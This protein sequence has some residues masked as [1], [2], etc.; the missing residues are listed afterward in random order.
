[1]TVMT[2][3]L[4]EEPQ[5]QK[6][7]EFINTID[8]QLTKMNWLIQTLLTLSKI[9]AGTVP[10]V[11]EPFAVSELIACSVRPFLIPLELKN[12]SLRLPDAAFTLTGDKNWTV[13]AL[14]NII[15]NCMEHTP[16]GGEIQIT[17]ATTAILS[18]IVIADNGSGID[19][20]E[21]PHI[22]DRFYKGKN[23]AS[24]SVGIG[25]ALAKSILQRQNASVTAESAPGQG[26]K[27]VIRFYKS[28]L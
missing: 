26:T 9:D 15:K 16:A 3:L 25:L 24:D 1:M 20:A 8:A 12:I 7:A 18:E 2:D 13:E 17:A 10:F 11:S 19:P 6:R 22:F 14:Q 23:S 5:P 21:L 4:K 27:F 28:I